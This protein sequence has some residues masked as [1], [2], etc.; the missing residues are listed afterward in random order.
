MDR[1]QP[2][3]SLKKPGP[4]KAAPFPSPTPAVSKNLT[5]FLSPADRVSDPGQVRRFHVSHGKAGHRIDCLLYIVP[6]LSQIIEQCCK[7]VCAVLYAA[8]APA[9]PRAFTCGT[10]PDMA[11]RKLLRNCSW[12]ITAKAHPKPGRLNVLLGAINVMVRS[13]I[14]GLSVAV[15]MCF[16]VPIQNKVAVNLI[17]ADHHIVGKAKFRNVGQFASGVSAAD[18]IVGTA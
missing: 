12:E 17:R 11:W 16:L 4:P 9:Y 15:G 7:P 13:A 5:G 2:K 8:R 3:V 1:G 6:V 10:M 14:S 18:R